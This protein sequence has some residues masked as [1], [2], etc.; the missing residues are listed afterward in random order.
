MAGLDGARPPKPAT[1]GVREGRLAQSVLSDQA[2]TVQDLFNFSKPARSR[3]F[4]P[5]LRYLPR[6]RDHES[7]PVLDIS[8]LGF[9]YQP[10]PVEIAVFDHEP[11]Q[12]FDHADFHLICDDSGKKNNSRILPVCAAQLPE[13]R[14]SQVGQCRCQERRMPRIDMVGLKWQ[15]SRTQAVQLHDLRSELSSDRSPATL[16]E[17]D[18]CL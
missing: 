7:K 5:F 1:F 12:S 14:I 10:I 16:Q 2:S 11:R 13:A 18:I 6:Q 8:Q 4:A 9:A 3:G 15:S 17:G